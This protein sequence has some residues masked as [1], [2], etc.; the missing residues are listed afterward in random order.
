MGRYNDFNLTF[1]R[2]NIFVSIK[3]NSKTKQKL[4]Y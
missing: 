2:I 4:K 1:I 3:L